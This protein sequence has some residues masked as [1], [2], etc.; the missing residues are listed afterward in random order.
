MS[1]GSRSA[2]IITCA[3]IE[4]FK[5]NLNGLKLIGRR[6]PRVRH[7]SDAERMEFRRGGHKLPHK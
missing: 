5:M 2:V 6:F 4:I 1:N 7:S 3:A